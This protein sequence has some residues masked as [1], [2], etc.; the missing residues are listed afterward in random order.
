MNAIEL[1]KKFGIEYAIKILNYDPSISDDVCHL[2][3]G[4]TENL[5]QIADDWELVFEH[6]SIGRAKK[7]ADSTYTAP[8]IKAVL[9]R[10][11]NLVEQCQ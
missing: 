3:F 8:E 7:Y 2:D 9:V 10:A 1:V 6:G 11:I 4:E 5:K